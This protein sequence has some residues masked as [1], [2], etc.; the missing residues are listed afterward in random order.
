[1]NVAIRALLFSFFL[2]PDL[3]SGWIITPRLSPS[4]PLNVASRCIS[5][6]GAASEGVN[7]ANTRRS[8]LVL[9]SS[10]GILSSDSSGDN[11]AAM[12]TKKVPIGSTP[13]FAIEGDSTEETPVQRALL[14]THFALVGANLVH[15]GSILASSSPLTLASAAPI[16]A[17]VA[18]SYVLGDFATGVF[19]WSVDNYGRLETPIVG[20]VCAAFQGH[21]DTPWTITFRSFA[22]NVYKICYNSIP[23]LLLTL[24]LAKTAFSAVFF[25]LFIN[26]WM[27]SQEFHKYS[28]MKQAPNKF[29][30]FLQGTGIILSRREHGRHHTS[31][32]EGKYC[33]LNGIC[34]PLLDNTNF[35]RHLE[36]IVFRLTGEWLTY[37]T[38]ACVLLL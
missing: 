27:M 36:R 18:L 16:A 1:M 19:H 32:F 33:I 37:C 21:H 12:V 20:S 14:M 30:G 8:S 9:A 6:S 4:R 2:F 5:D 7:P 22:N 3:S 25:S 26:W 11:A 17:A 24:L 23:A 35:F 34:N 15:A 10:N 28:H 29:V 31:P 38:C 13:N